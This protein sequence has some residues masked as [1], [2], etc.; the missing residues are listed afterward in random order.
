MDKER[1]LGY[2]TA[3]DFETASGYSPCSIGIAVVKN[4]TVAETE[5]L[6]I[7]PEP[8]VFHPFNTVI[9]GITAED[10]KNS[11]TFAQLWPQL[12]PYIEGQIVVAHNAPFDIGVLRHTLQ[13]YNIEEPQMDILCSCNAARKAYPDFSSHGLGAVCK[14]LGIPLQHHRADS[15]AAG[16]AEILCRI[17]REH[18]IETMVELKQKLLLLPGFLRNGRYKPCRA[19]AHSVD[20]AD[21]PQGKEGFFYGKDVVFSGKLGNLSRKMAFDAVAKN[22]GYPQNSVT[23]STDVLVLGNAE[24]RKQQQGQQSTKFQKALQLQQQGIEIL[25]LSEDEFLSRIEY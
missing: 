8:N 22:G 25:I 1:E 4:G 21:V 16:S 10:V 19:I 9:H 17:L 3:I 15:D 12:Y 23:Q 5:H 6:L 14:A 7:R 2:F 18:D 11:P 13:Q 24:Y 20:V